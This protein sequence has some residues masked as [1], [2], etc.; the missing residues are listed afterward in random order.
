MIR[1]RYLALAL[2]IATAGCGGNSAQTPA[3][4]PA[5]GGV[6]HVKTSQGVEGEIVGT[7]AMGSRFSR[8]AIGMSVKQVSDLIGEPTDQSSHITGKSFIPFYFGG[9]ASRIEYFYKGEG[10]LSFSNASFGSG[11]YVLTRI[12]VNPAESGYAH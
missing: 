2:L 6:Q 4:A 9:D 5:A 3:T 10:Q 1:Q 8:V 11:N 12:E 7:P